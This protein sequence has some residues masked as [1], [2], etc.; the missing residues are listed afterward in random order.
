MSELPFNL[1]PAPAV[2]NR[3]VLSD[4][5]KY[6]KTYEGWV[7]VYDIDSPMSNNEHLFNMSD[8]S[9]DAHTRMTSMFDYLKTIIIA[10]NFT[11]VTV[12]SSG[13]ESITLRPQPR[14]GG[15][16]GLPDSLIKPIMEGYKDATAASKNS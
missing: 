6:D 5:G 8:T 12:D 2:K 14:E 13:N 4:L 1:S 10:W 11:Q 3:Y 7:V 16:E 15:L 9:L